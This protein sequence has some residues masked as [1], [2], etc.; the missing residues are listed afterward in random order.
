MQFELVLLPRLLDGLRPEV[1]EIVRP[2]HFEWHE[3]VNLVL[4][5][6][7]INPEDAIFLAYPPLHRLGN[8][9]PRHGVSVRAEPPLIPNRHSAGRVLRV[10]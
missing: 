6:R 5:A 3:M 8:M 10:G 7:A 2:A 1:P 4:R 9:S